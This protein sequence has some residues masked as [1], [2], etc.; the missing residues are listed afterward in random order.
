MRRSTTVKE[1]TGDAN[2]GI[3]NVL[4]SLSETVPGSHSIVVYPDVDVL[5]EIYQ[6]YVKEQLDDNHI[7]LLL[8]YYETI[9]SVKN[10][11]MKVQLNVDQHLRD[12]SLQIIDGNELFFNGKHENGL[13]E[14]KADNVVSLMRI[15][16]TKVRKMQKDGATVILD[17][18][19]FFPDEEIDTLIEYEKSIPHSFKDTTFKQFCMLHQRDFEARFT[20]RD[21]AKILDEHGRSI[22]MVDN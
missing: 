6:S 15:M 10:S 8:P 13:L 12:H 7:V 19:C 18:G 20:S 21:K 14:N 1:R 16:Q 5:R 17:L 2:R 11:L 22:I 4:S 3:R 9:D